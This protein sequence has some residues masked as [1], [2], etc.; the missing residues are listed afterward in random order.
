VVLCCVICWKLIAKIPR[1]RVLLR[2]IRG[3]II[4]GCVC[5]RKLSWYGQCIIYAR[6][7]VRIPATTKKKIKRTNIDRQIKQNQQ[8]TLKRQPRTLVCA[9]YKRVVSIFLTRDLVCVLIDRGKEEQAADE[10]GRGLWHFKWET[11]GVGEAMEG[12]EVDT[13]GVIKECF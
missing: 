2:Q 8:K 1:I 7:G 4:R 13:I 3:G 6:Y 5:K 11:T 12:G 10:V 9:L